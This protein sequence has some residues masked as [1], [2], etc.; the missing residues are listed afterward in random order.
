[1][2]SRKP[3]RKED[4]D[5]GEPADGHRPEGEN[6]IKDSPQMIAGRE[7]RRDADEAPGELRSPGTRMNQHDAHNEPSE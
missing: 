7:F 4:V 6:K 2:P 3:A 5:M 1:M